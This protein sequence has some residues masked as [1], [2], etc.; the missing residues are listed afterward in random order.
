[1]DS[2]SRDWHSGSSR[3]QDGESKSDSVAMPRLEKMYRE[4]EVS[5]LRSEMSLLEQQ[6]NDIESQISNLSK[7][8]KRSQAPRLE[9]ERPRRLL[10]STPKVGQAGK[11]SIFPHLVSS[12][13]KHTDKESLKQKP[14]EETQVSFFHQ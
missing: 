11:G 8:D 5:R 1:M 14:P 12:Q 9:Q 13:D 10:P 6:L 3:D 7:T 2:R 4:M